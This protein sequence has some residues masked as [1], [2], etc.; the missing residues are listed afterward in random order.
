MFA[1][2]PDILTTKDLQE[3]LRLSKGSALSLLN[4]NEITCFKK[5]R[6]FLIPKIHLIEYIKN[7][8]RKS[9]LRYNELTTN[10]EPHNRM[11]VM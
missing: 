11:E 2:Y 3:I 10:N 6:K 9:G 7:S 1:N 5:G 4:S 8:C